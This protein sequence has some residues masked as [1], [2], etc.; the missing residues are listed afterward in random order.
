MPHCRYLS[1]K[2]VT[3]VSEKKK[4]KVPHPEWS[5]GSVVGIVDSPEALTKSLKLAPG[6]VDYL[7]WRADFMGPDLPDSRLPWVVTARHPDEG[8]QNAMNA[9]Q[10]RDAL[11]QMLPKASIVD[12]EV[13]SLPVMKKVVVAAHSQ[14]V[15][16]AC[17][18]HDFQKTPSTQRLKEVIDRAGDSGANAVKIATMTR[19]PSDIGRLLDLWSYS[20]LPLALMGMGPLGM[21]SRLLFANCGSV[22]NY[23]WL[24]QPNV[25]GQ[26]S[27]WELKALINKSRL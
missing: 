12:V 20:P 1:V 16:V 5:S 19:F 22:L 15:Q 10:R 25:P 26:W 11:L 17:S 13:R 14:G 9:V 18:F 8:G 6:E 3:R 24:H 27:A 2:K 7:E 23:G 4:L 21:A